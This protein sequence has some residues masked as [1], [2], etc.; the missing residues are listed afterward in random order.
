MKIKLNQ[1]NTSKMIWTDS[2]CTLANVLQ[3]PSMDNTE[4][5]KYGSIYFKDEV[6]KPKKVFT[7][8]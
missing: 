3:N 7:E 1:R 4:R 5:F 8:F 2:P 6:N